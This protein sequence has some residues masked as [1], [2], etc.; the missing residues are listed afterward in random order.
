VTKVRRTSL[1]LIDLVT[2]EPALVVDL[3]P[4]KP[5]QFVAPVVDLSTPE[6][7]QLV[8]ALSVSARALAMSQRRPPGLQLLTPGLRRYLL[9]WRPHPRQNL[10]TVGMAYHCITHPERPYRQKWYYVGGTLLLK[11]VMAGFARFLG[12]EAELL[13]FWLYGHAIK[14]DE[15][16]SDVCYIYSPF[17]PMLL[18]SLCSLAWKRVTLLKSKVDEFNIHYFRK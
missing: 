12:L 15:T 13:Y 16:I 4:P 14:P 8:A 10:I 11:V 9:G 6:P 18:I 1:A 5:A 2:P 7:D 3:S 17:I